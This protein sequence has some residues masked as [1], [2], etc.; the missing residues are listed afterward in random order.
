MQGH[1]Q[2]HCEQLQDL[3]CSIDHKLFLRSGGEAHRLPLDC[4]ARLG[5]V[6]VSS[7]SGALTALLAFN[8]WK[9][10]GHEQHQIIRRQP[11]RLHHSGIHVSLLTRRNI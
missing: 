2:N 7:G 10:E 9:K 11:V 6:Y 4:R 5:R 1:I 3:A 8:P